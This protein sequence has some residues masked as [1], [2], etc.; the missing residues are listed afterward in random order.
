MI[1]YKAPPQPMM[2]KL[3]ENL[4][5]QLVL[6]FFLGAGTVY[7]LRQNSIQSTQARV[8]FLKGS[9]LQLESSESRNQFYQETNQAE[10][11]S[12]ESE[13]Q[14]AS[15]MGASGEITS[16]DLGPAS[17]PE[18]KIFFLQVSTST[19]N[20]W[21]EDGTLTRVESSDGIMMGYVGELPKILNV[22]QGQLKV[23]KSETF[24]M[25]LEQIY[26]SKIA[27]P[28]SENPQARTVASP[29]DDLNDGMTAFATL[30]SIK[31]DS[32]T[33]QLEISLDAQNSF[34]VQ[35]EMSPGSSVLVT[36]FAKLKNVEKSPDSELIVVLNLKK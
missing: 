7:W 21:L 30:E 6:I 27:L 4:F 31:D 5:I 10:D 12:N 16:Q 14:Q 1:A 34:P 32:I 28:K 8:E 19:L 11:S 29:S 2:K 15:L 25:A 26:S 18:V 24:A 13:I 9:N 3:A 33:G 22:A 36:G 23:L 17:K 20:K 35:F